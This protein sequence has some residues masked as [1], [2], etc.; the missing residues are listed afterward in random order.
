[1]QGSNLS[2]VV[3]DGYT[4][5]PGDISW[6]PI[7]RYGRLD[8]Y[9]RSDE[10]N[11][12][13]RAKH[14]NL[15]LLNKFVLDRKKLESLENLQGI[16][17]LATGYNNV[18]LEAC[19]SR[20]IKVYNAVGYGAESVAQ[21]VIAAMLAWQ[22]RIESHAMDVRQGGWSRCPDFSYTLHA[23]QEIAGKTM[24]VVGFGKIGASVGRKA[25]G[26]GMN[27]VAY[28][29]HPERD[30]QP[31]MRMVSVEEL[32][33]TSDVI[34]LHVPLT[35]QTHQFI[36]ADSLSKMQSHALLINT[37][38]GGLVDE[39]ALAYA[40]SNKLIQ[41]AILDVLNQEPPPADHPFYSL[42][43]CWVTPHMAWTSKQARMRL[44][45][46]SAENIGHFLANEDINRVG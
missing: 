43:N 46:I 33:K 23:G 16:I 12:L 2:M 11:W 40:L 17:V 22:T 3:L 31:W 39:D 36:N 9:D 44:I 45:S 10:S 27:V 28:H 7:E 34:S 41:G 38:R 24:G 8:V 5:N 20:G 42:P 4:N 15:V 29:K 35:D 25:Y 18:D 14:A 30:G 21:Y 32:L 1:M 19:R 26:L 6:E 13:D 37:G